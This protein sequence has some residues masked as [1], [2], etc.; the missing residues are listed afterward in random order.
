MPREKHK[1]EETVTKLRQVDV[2]VAIQGIGVSE[3]TYHRWRASRSGA[4]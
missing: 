3:V 2:A 4:R 1:P